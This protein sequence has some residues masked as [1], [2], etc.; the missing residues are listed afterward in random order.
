MVRGLLSDTTGV[1]MPSTNY[2]VFDYVTNL[3]NWLC[4]VVVSERHTFTFTRF[5]PKRKSLIIVVVVVYWSVVIADLKVIRSMLNA[6]G[7]SRSG[8]C[9][10]R[11]VIVYLPVQ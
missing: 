11:C 7:L 6:F 4:R 1:L 3:T 9:R 8:G 10:L 2:H 5:N